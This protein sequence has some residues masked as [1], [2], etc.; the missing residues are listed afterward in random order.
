[1]SLCPLSCA[2]DGLKGSVTIGLCCPLGF[3]AAGPHQAVAELSY[4]NE[5]FP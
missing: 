1:M 4:P 5:T 3:C 2:V